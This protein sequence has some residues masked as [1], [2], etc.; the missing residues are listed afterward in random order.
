MQL[1]C[2]WLVV[3]ANP[4]KTLTNMLSDSFAKKNMLIDI[5]SMQ[6]CLQSIQPVML[7]SEIRARSNTGARAV[8]AKT[9]RAERFFSLAGVHECG[10]AK[11]S[12][13]NYELRRFL[14]SRRHMRSL[15]GNHLS[16]V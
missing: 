16:S 6:V 5:T 10:G 3:V 11:E 14:A 13:S 2:R 12:V 1:V 9:A 7:I 4:W 15:H 8:F